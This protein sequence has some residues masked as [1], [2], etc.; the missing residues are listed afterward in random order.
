MKNKREEQ[1][2]NLHMPQQHIDGLV[3]DGSISS[4]LAL[5]ILQYWTKP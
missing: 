4:V 2:E 3:Q 5:E 1:V